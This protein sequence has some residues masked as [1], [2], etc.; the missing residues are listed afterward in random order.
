MGCGGGRAQRGRDWRRRISHLWLACPLR[1]EPS[2]LA[3]IAGA[4]AAG[5]RLREACANSLAVWLAVWLAVL[6]KAHSISR[7]GPVESCVDSVRRLRGA[8]SPVVHSN[9]QGIYLG[10]R[11]RCSSSQGDAGRELAA[12]KTRSQA[13]ADRCHFVRQVGGDLAAQPLPIHRLAK[14][15]HAPVPHAWV[16]S[17]CGSQ[18]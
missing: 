17:G 1:R 10:E 14:H 9:A 3:L 5:D 6:T 2:V 12:T 7:G 8:G 13:F 16:G 4:Y 15:P 11:C 18:G